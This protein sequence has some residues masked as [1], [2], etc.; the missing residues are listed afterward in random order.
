MRAVR[1]LGPS[2]G[3]RVVSDAPAPTLAPGWVL[4]RVKRAAITHTD[5]ALGLAQIST[6]GPLTLGHEFVG[7]VEQTA[8]GASPRDKALAEDLRNAR[9]V[10]SPAIACA[11]C[12]LCRRGLSAHCREGRCIGLRGADG[13]FADRVAVPIRNLVRVPDNLDDETALLAYPV[14]SA[15]HAASQVHL[16]SKTYVTV[17]GDSMVALLS[18]QIMARRNASVRMLA[19]DDARL[20]VCD[21]WGVRNRLTDDVGRRADQDVVIECTGTAEGIAMA[22]EMVRPRG[23]IVLKNPGATGS[24]PVSISRITASEIHLLGSFGGSLEE[25]MLELGSGRV[26]V[27]PLIA[28]RVRLEDAESALK[29][30]S[31]REHLRMVFEI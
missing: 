2:G 14:A 8:T 9:V 25:A 24:I 27:A 1:R 21:R 23:T 19:G 12:D 15:L 16:E 11:A 18:A 3:L 7:V 22:I 28:R 10:A 6:D 13:C 30:A 5:V 4:V 26:D 20:A 17:L 29:A 31:R